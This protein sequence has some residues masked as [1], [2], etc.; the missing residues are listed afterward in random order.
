MKT[1]TLAIRLAI[2]SVAVCSVLMFGCGE[3]QQEAVARVVAASGDVKLR[4]QIDSEFVAAAPDMAVRRSGVIKTGEQSGATVEILNKG[5]ISFKSDVVFKFANSAVADVI[6]ESGTAV[7]KIEKDGR[8]FKAK[9]PQGVSCVLGTIFALV[10]N[11]ASFELWVKEGTVEFISEAGKSH[12]VT[13]NQRLSI[14]SGGRADLAE[15]GVGDLESVFADP[16]NM[17]PFNS[18]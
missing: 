13:E 5:T 9:T 7:Y 15:V 2:I 11:E 16:E 4:Q 6:Q 14:D 1:Q 8:G 3:N 17:L 18:R 12:R 10:I